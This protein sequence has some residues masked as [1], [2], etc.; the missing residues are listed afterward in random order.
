M[1]LLVVK[2]WLKLKFAEN[3]QPIKKIKKNLNSL[4]GSTTATNFS[5]SGTNLSLY[6][7][8][9]DFMTESAIRDIKFIKCDG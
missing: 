5:S 4:D 3:T 6:K 2:A 7:F 9:Y 8:T 1:E